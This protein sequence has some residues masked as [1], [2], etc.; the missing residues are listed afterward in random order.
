MKK[1]LPLL[2]LFFALIPNLAQAQMCVRDSNILVVGGLL[3][4]APWSPDSAFY[5]LALACINEPYNQSVTINVP[6][7]ITFMNFTVPI[8]NVSIPTSNGIG[9]YPAGMTYLCDPPNCVF[10][11]NTLGCILMFGTPT[12]ANTAPDTLDLELTAT[13]LTSLGPLPVIFPG[14]DLA[15]DDH[16]YLILN[17]TGECTSSASDLNSPFSA[18]RAVPNPVSHQTRI[19]VQSSQSGV[20]QFEVFNLVGKRVFVQTVQLYEGANQFTFDAGSLATGAY[21]YSLGNAEGRSVR[22]LVKF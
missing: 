7:T 16:Y 19:E 5:N 18:L 15:P 14:N 3:S 8:V 22:R 12:N 6:P 11:A 2:F 10:N 1:A 9:N 17:P 20:F 21:M 13:V 4:P